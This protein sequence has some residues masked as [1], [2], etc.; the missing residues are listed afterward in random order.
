MKCPTGDSGPDPYRLEEASEFW[1]IGVANSIVGTV[2]I[3]G[4]IAAILVL[5]R[6]SMRENPFNA[7]LVCLAASDTTF[8][9]IMVLMAVEFGLDIRPTMPYYDHVVPMELLAPAFFM[10][11]TS[12][13]L[14][15][16]SVAIERHFRLR[17]LSE[18]PTI[19][20]QVGSVNSMVRNQ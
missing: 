6:P 3:A 1:L 4:S 5:A 16:V 14:L 19:N 9:V 13:I 20:G 15:T 8:L 2:G 11:R 17:K 18:E 10:A 12:G 7:L